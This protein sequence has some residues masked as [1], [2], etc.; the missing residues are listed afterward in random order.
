MT[1]DTANN[2][3]QSRVGG[4]VMPEL[5]L[6]NTPYVR[7]ATIRGEVQE[8]FRKSSSPGMDGTRELFVPETKKPAAWVGFFA[9]ST[10]V[11]WGRIEPPTQVFSILGLNT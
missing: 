4:S 10:L 8:V 2:V 11:V 6:K 9:R 1:V 3:A 5:C 7:E